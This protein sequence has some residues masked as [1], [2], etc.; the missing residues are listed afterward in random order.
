VLEQEAV[1]V[2]LEGEGADLLDDS[3][4]ARFETPA[5]AEFDPVVAD[6]TEEIYREHYQLLLYV[7]CRKFRVPEEDAEALIQEIFVSYLSAGAG[8]RDVRAWLVAAVSNASRH[9]WRIH[10]RTESLPEN[11]GERSDPLSHGLA[12]TFARRLTMHQTLGYLHE[13]CRETLRLH[14]FEGCSAME[15]ARRLDTTNRYAEKLI[16]NCLK[17][18]HEIYKNLTAVK[19]T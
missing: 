16:H 14:Y 12:E 8:I 9:Y 7:A 1:G 19:R 17:R 5:T 3:A 15:V 6:P 13:K 2:T 10:G 18:A 11:F 4:P